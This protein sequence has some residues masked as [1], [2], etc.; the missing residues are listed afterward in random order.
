MNRNA[1][2]GKR[3][4]RLILAQASRTDF[5]S[6]R[7][8]NAKRLVCFI[9]RSVQMHQL[10]LNGCSGAITVVVRLVATHANASGPGAEHRVRWDVNA[11]IA[12]THDAARK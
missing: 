6:R 7:L 10:G 1:G 3:V 5:H 12:V 4:F 11:V 9:D 2:F 8:R